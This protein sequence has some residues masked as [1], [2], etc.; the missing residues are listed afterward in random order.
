MI[1][2]L[3]VIDK[4]SVQGSGLHGIARAL[5]WWCARLPADEFSCR[6]LSLRGHE[7]EAADLFARENVDLRFVDLGKFSPRTLGVLRREIR[8]F[9]ADILH[10][11]GYAAADFGRIAARLARIP[12]IVHEHVV[13]PKQPLYQDIADRLLAPLTTRALAI[14][15][16]VAQFMRD[17]RH[18]P[19]SILDTFFYGIPFDT[20]LEPSATE[21]D[22]ARAEAKIPP[23]APVLV[24]AGR[25]AQQKDLPTLLQAFANL[26]P[27]TCRLLII[28]E[29]PERAT[30]ERLA[31]DLGLRERVF[32]A[33]FR[34][35]VRPWMALGDIFV[36]PS[37]YEGGPLTLFEAMRLSKPVVSTPVGLVPEALRD[38]ET[39]YLTPLSDPIALAQRLQ[40]LLDNPALR[41]HM[42]Q[43]AYRESEKWDV[44]H[45]VAKLAAIYRTLK[46]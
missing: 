2:V 41:R 6:V 17:K 21:L 38:G 10:L 27:D 18:I 23:G 25:L 15:E 3:H 11:H 29:G 20:F 26:R 24:T 12:N 32:L 33:G 1:R 46:T 39:G 44:T 14:S 16:P 42:G 13:F 7:T 31:N 9:R 5:A 34:K 45:A 30:V 28:G 43:A 37:L 40:R 22:A 35:D 4:M 19:A 36:I 8:D